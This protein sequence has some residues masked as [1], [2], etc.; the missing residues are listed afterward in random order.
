[1]MYVHQPF[2][3]FASWRETDNTSIAKKVYRG[4]INSFLPALAGT[5]P[6]RTTQ[7]MNFSSPRIWQFFYIVFLVG[8]TVGRGLAVGLG[9]WGPLGALQRQIA[10]YRNVAF[11]DSAGDNWECVSCSSGIRQRHEMFCSS[12]ILQLRV[13]LN[14]RGR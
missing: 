1:M 14:R 5:G 11:S 7:F 10:S 2:I 6:L 13:S 12:T 8:S 9:L 3:D 4:N